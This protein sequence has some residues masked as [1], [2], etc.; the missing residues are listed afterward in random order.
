MIASE[1]PLLL[2]GLQVHAVEESPVSF[3]GGALAAKI[4]GVPVLVHDPDAVR[5]GLHH[6]IPRMAVGLVARHVPY[7]AG[8]S[9]RLVEI[10]GK[11]LGP[12]FDHVFAHD[13]GQVAPL[14]PSDVQHAVP[15]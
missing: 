9:R 13:Q 6:R 10:H 8:G 2:E 7:Q 5:Q 12:V 3:R 15:D 11:Q 4:D 14:T 1:E